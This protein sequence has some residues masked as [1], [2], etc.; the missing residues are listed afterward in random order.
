MNIMK[1]SETEKKLM[2]F[3]DEI[4]I[5]DCHEHLE[6]EDTRISKTLDV[7][8]LFSHYTKGDLLISGMKENDYNELYS[9]DVPLE[10]RWKKFTPFWKYIRHTSYSRAVLIALKKFYGFDD[11]TEENYIVI[12][13]KIQEFNKPGIYKKILR[14]ACNIKTCLTQ[15]GRTKL[16]TDLL[17]S[18]MPMLYDLET[19]EG[20]LHPDFAPGVEIR[21][22]DDYMLEIEKYIVRVKKEGAVG[23]K[24]VSLPYSETDRKE[25]EDIFNGI[26]S[27]RMEVSISTRPFFTRPTL[28]RNYLTDYAINLAG[29]YDMVVAVHTGYW[30]DFRDLHPLH[31]IPLLI[32]HPDVRFDIYHLGYPWVRDTLMLGKGFPNVWLNFC[33]T[34]IISQRF[35]TEALDEAIDLIPVNK[36]LAFGGDYRCSSLEKIYGHLT[37]AE[38]DIAKVLAKR[39]EDGELNEE[40]VE[41]IIKRWFYDNAVELYK[42]R[43]K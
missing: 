17:T 43:L 16:G 12:S 27:G 6:P 37:M 36:I 13:Q 30:G 23:L 1:L 8:T 42:L 22:L 35:A 39:L 41:Y 3:M 31:M 10:I 24:M 7:F 21:T 32:K 20:L 28:L 25:A 4:E 26:S 5:I 2:K 19:K 15:C 29:K 38:E 18:V 33:W 34:H 14:D 11:I 9:Q 40:D